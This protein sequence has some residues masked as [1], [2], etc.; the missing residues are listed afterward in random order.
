M[1]GKFMLEQSAGG[2]ITCGGEETGSLKKVSVF[3]VACVTG[4]RELTD[5]MAARAILSHV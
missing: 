3:F 4:N 2:A 5:L 1:Y